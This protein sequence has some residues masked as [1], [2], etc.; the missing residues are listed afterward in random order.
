MYLKEKR[1]YF[2]IIATPKIY[3]VTDRGWVQ[4]H[5]KTTKFA[6]L[7]PW[8]IIINRINSG[9]CGHKDHWKVL[10]KSEAFLEIL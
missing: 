8:H 4:I 1:T 2:G 6:S 3:K 5:P 10:T 7:T 9:I